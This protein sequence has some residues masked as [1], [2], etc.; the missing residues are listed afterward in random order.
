MV[1]E[2][3]P[4][5]LKS[6]LVTVEEAF[7]SKPEVSVWRLLHVLLVVVP[8]ARENVLSAERS[9]PPCIGYVVEIVREVATYPERSVNVGSPREDVASCCQLP[10]A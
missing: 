7:T 10:P 3:P 4:F 2:A 8:K 9:P 6:P 5:A 1:V